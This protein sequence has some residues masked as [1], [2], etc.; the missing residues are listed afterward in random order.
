MEDIGIYFNSNA[1]SANVDANYVSEQSW[2]NNN[3]KDA[4]GVYGNTDSAK[5]RF[6]GYRFTSTDGK[7]V[8]LSLGIERN[9]ASDSAKDYQCALYKD[10]VFKLLSSDTINITE[11]VKTPFSCSFDVSALS[12]ADKTDAEIRIIGYNA[13]AG[14]QTKFHEAKIEVQK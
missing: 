4:N 9:N 7:A 11:K 2:N 10:G 6:V 1:I 12:A 13:T 14:A 8:R 5:S 3:S